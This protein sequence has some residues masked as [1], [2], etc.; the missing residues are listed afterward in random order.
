MGQTG[1]L[2]PKKWG[3]L[4]P[5]HNPIAGKGPYYYRDTELFMAEFATDADAVLDLLPSDFELLEPAG[6]F[7]I[8]EYN[9]WTSHGPYG[10]V[11][12][13]VMCTFEGRAC[14]YVPGVYVTTENSQLLGREI[15]GFGKKRCHKF[16][17]I[18]HGNSQIEVQ[19]EVF[20]G[21]RALRAVMS[22]RI[23]ET[24]DSITEIPLVCLRI[25]PDPGRRRHSFISAAG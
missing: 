15:W 1:R 11:Y 19:M 23:N 7:M 10:E 13:G 24:A 22:P 17:L 3:S 5:A 4:M 25:C 9:H 18:R 6:A 21:D 20:P 8:M 14:A 2:T 12:L 16:D